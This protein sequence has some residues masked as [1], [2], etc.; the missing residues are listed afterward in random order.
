M[1]TSGSAHADNSPHGNDDTSDAE[2]AES[3]V[4]GDETS[5]S[6]EPAFLS[7]GF[8]GQPKYGCSLPADRSLLTLGTALANPLYLTH[9]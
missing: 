5:P 8:I 9:S 7:I 2:Q 6:T 3:A 4:D 1:N